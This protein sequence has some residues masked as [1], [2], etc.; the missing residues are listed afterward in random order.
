MTGDHLSPCY[1]HQLL[2]SDQ[3]KH[4]SSLSEDLGIGSQIEII[5]RP[6]AEF[7]LLRFL[8]WKLQHIQ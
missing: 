5:S 4:L 8:A 7:V 2:C 6:P 1:P 3:L